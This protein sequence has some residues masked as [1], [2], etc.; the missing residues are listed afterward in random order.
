MSDQE[1]LLLA[2]RIN[3]IYI[4]MHKFKNNQFR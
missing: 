3:S 4:E 1:I 2:I